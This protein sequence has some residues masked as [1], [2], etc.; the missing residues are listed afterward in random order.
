M[1]LCSVTMGTAFGNED[2]PI[3]PHTPLPPRKHKPPLN[4]ITSKS[5]QMDTSDIP[6]AALPLTTGSDQS[7][8]VLDNRDEER[9]L[10]ASELKQFLAGLLPNEVVAWEGQSPVQTGSENRM[11]MSPP[12]GQESVSLPCSKGKENLLL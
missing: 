10:G 2:S 6:Y 11:E 1:T 5:L 4:V 3:Q 12:L 8:S 9:E 7:W